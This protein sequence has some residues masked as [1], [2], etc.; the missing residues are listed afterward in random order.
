MMVTPISL[1]SDVL[2]LTKL[3]G[4]SKIKGKEGQRWQGLTREKKRGRKGKPGGSKMS[5]S[6]NRWGSGNPS[7]FL[8]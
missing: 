1:R 6:G 5:W 4:I 7:D 2:T 3:R 8:A